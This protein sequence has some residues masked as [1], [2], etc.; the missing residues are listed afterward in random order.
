MR[1]SDMQEKG[2]LPVINPVAARSLFVLEP[3]SELIQPRKNVENLARVQ[4]RAP[5]GNDWAFTAKS[6]YVK[7]VSNSHYA[8]S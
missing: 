7:T 2:G 4:I 6:V 1:Y 5:G 8:F 3:I